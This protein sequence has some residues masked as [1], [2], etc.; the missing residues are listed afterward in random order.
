MEADLLYLLE[1]EKKNEKN[2]PQMLL[3]Q[4]DYPFQPVDLMVVNNFEQNLW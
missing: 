1:T 2:L 3:Y 4:I